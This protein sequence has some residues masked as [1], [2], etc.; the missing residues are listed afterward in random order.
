MKTFIATFE[1]KVKYVVT[2]EDEARD[3]ALDHEFFLNSTWGGRT[4]SGYAKTVCTKLMSID[5]ENK[6]DDH[7]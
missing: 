1:V 5:Q 3:H 7:V 4:G 6:E 2:S